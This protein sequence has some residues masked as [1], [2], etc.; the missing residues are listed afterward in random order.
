MVVQVHKGSDAHQCTVIGCIPD[1][2]PAAQG[3]DGANI[4]MV[5]LASASLTLAAC[6]SGIPQV[7][8][9]SLLLVDPMSGG[10]PRAAMQAGSQAFTCRLH[11]VRLTAS[12][13]SSAHRS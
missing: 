9:A 3:V 10:L 1:L 7:W 2:Q 12:P 4:G 13:H 11:L 6:S 8:V 5:Q